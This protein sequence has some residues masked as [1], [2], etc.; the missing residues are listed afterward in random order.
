MA[1]QRETINLISYHETDAD[2]R[3]LIT[4]L[5]VIIQ[6]ESLAW[7]FVSSTFLSSESKRFQKQSEILRSIS[8]SVSG[9]RN[10]VCHQTPLTGH[11]AINRSMKALISTRCLEL[12]S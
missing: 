11:F 4:L 2:P 6:S 9:H 12:L 8:F 1:N 7:T 3:D 5:L 10:T